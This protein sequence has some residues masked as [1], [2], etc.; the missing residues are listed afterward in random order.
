MT[1]LLPFPLLAAALFAM[2]VL[3]TG[4]SP[5]HVLLGALVAL[6]VSRVMLVLRPQPVR[7]R[8][9]G[10]MIRLAA[11]VFVDIVRSN[12]AV[13]G[14]VLFRPEARRSGFIRFPTELRSPYAL[15][16]LAVIITATPGTLWVQHDVGR[17]EVLIHV[18]DLA[19]EG[20]WIAFLR[21]RYER[22]LMDIFP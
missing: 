7:I 5:G 20:E 12:V 1:R 18:L 21:E 11:F 10:A 6:L 14:I 13:A 8:F 19:D 9:G 22:L 3:L 16:V 17:H 4:F 15:A 2:W